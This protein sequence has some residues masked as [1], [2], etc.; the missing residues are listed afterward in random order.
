MTNLDTL[1]N[2][3]AG[4]SK[5][6]VTELGTLKWENLSPADIICGVTVGIDHLLDVILI[7]CDNDY[8][9]NTKINII[10]EQFS[11]NGLVD[12]VNKRWDDEVYN[13]INDQ[14]IRLETHC[15]SLQN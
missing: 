4:E 3:L 7:N 13:F 15:L 5:F 6:I 8:F 11:T 12:A 14:K 10:S 2:E 1:K 9:Y